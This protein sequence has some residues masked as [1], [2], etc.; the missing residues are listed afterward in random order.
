MA[1]A[2]GLIYGINGPVV[3]VKGSRDFGMLQMVKVGN[4]GLIGEVIGV[5]P[6]NAIVQVYE[7]TTG[8]KPGEP[9]ESMGIPMSVTLRP[10]HFKQHFRRHRTPA[11]GIGNEKR[12]VYRARFK[13]L[14][15]G[16]GKKVERNPV[17][18][19]GRQG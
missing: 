16:H 11:E 4:E 10:G 9:V 1:T 3:H 19:S 5:E 2:K 8:L 13:H 14:R 17:L 7:S 12:R 15:S 6:D 18:Q